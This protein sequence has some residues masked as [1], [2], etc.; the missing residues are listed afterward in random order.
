MYGV[1]SAYQ[2]YYDKYN[3]LGG[4]EPDNLVSHY[5]VE[6]LFEAEREAR[7]RAT[8]I[9]K[10]NCTYDMYEFVVG[11]AKEIDNEDE[12]QTAIAEMCPDEFCYD[13]Y[14]WET[15]G[16]KKHCSEGI[17]QYS[18]KDHMVL[19]NFYADK[20]A[21]LCL[22]DSEGK[23][24]GYEPFVAAYNY[25]ANTKSWSQGHY[26]ASV[27]DAVEHIKQ[28]TGNMK[29]ESSLVI[30]QTQVTIEDVMS[31]YNVSEAKAHNLLVAACKEAAGSDWLRKLVTDEI[32]YILDEEINEAEAAKSKSV[33]N[34]EI[35]K[36]A[37]STPIAA[38][39]K[40]GY[41][42]V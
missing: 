33:L 16:T 28:Q 11:I 4:D 7:Q 40:S 8:E 17:T 1:V 19:E 42:E 22:I 27:V 21:L 35:A 24:R 25:D 39:A 14:V 32:N 15:H 18:S 34:N 41:E 23:P 9:F 2:A 20:Y 31:D 13:Y 5:E 29:E 6:G 10:D 37:P 36:T 30:K 38:K 26:F 12:L 3:P